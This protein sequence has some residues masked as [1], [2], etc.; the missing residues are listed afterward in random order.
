MKNIFI[1]LFFVLFLNAGEK[2]IKTISHKSKYL[3]KEQKINIYIPNTNGPHSVLY[4]LHGAWGKY[5]NWV[6]IT[7]IEYYAD[8]YNFLI[9]MPDG[10]E[11]SWYIDSPIQKNWNYESYFIKE[12]IPFIDSNFATVKNKN[13]RAICGLSMGGFGAMHFGLKYSDSFISVSSLSGVLNILKYAGTKPNL[14]T[15]FGSITNSVWKENDLFQLL[16]KNKSELNLKFDIG[17]LDKY[18]TDNREFEEK[19]KS[20]NIP[21]SYSEKK[22]K[23]DWDYWKE[24]ISEHLEFHSNFLLNAKK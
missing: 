24:N 3:E 15:A 7:D 10:G 18:L 21:F 16:E 1:F 5:S 13:G 20:L 19:L 12:L 23:H 11:F 2:N 6:E 14:D 8:K 22:G 17:L 9:V 4:L